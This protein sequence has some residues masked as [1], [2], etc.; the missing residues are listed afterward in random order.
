MKQEYKKKLEEEKIKIKAQ[1]D[2]LK[3]DKM[4]EKMNQIRELEEELIVL[5]SKCSELKN[6]KL[7]SD[8]YSK[9]YIICQKE[10]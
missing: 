1:Y 10:I 9:V 7:N 5:K 4:K 8:S 3:D 2:Q 6:V